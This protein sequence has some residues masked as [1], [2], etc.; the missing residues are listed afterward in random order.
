M[1]LI[2]ALIVAGKNLSEK[3]HKELSLFERKAM[4]EYMHSKLTLEKDKTDK[5]I[6]TTVKRY[7]SHRII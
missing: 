4:E 7:S 3:E 2:G 5:K 1:Y 6:Q